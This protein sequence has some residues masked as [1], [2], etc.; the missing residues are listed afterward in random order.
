VKEP[1]HREHA[2][3]KVSIRHMVAEEPRRV[4]AFVCLGRAAPLRGTSGRRGWRRSVGGVWRFD[5]RALEE[6]AG[7]FLVEENEDGRTGGLNPAPFNVSSD[8]QGNRD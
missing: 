4:F 7:I 2:P 5:C 3:L 1:A 8:D 6:T